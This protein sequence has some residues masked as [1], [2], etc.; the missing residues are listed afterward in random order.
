MTACRA[1]DAVETNNP[2][3]TFVADIYGIID[4]RQVRGIECSNCYPVEG[5]IS[6]LNTARD[7]ERPV[8]GAGIN[9]RP[10]NNKLIALRIRMSAEGVC[11]PCA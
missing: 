5:S 4:A 10:A 11:I 7:L 2:Y 1:D 8:S 9:S 3:I 6:V